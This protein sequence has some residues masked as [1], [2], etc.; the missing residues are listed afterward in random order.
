MLNET[1]IIGDIAIIS[2]DEIK[3][4][5]RGNFAAQY[6]AVTKQDYISMAYN[7]PSKYGKLKR[8][9]IELDT[10]SYNQR[11]LNYYILAEDS[12][13]FLIEAND[14]LKNNLKTW[15]NQYKM[16]NDTID[17]LDAKVCNIGIE[18]EA[19]AFPGTN[20]YDLLNQCNKLLRAAFTK[21][22]YIGEPILIT[23]IYQILKSVP[24][25][26]DVQKHKLLLKLVFHMQIL[27]LQ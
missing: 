2:P 18:F 25:L 11:N 4:R 12:D 22:F 6:R 23:D 19:T 24:N 10:D 13:G 5:A 15:I 20:K 8:I 3:E 14:S 1:P 17:I 27:Q 26:L 9:A 7:M 21:T 16:I